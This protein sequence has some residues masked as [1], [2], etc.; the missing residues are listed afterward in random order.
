MD[1]YTLTMKAI[2]WIFI[3]FST[4]IF[5][6]TSDNTRNGT[7]LGFFH[8]KQLPQDY[9]LWTEAQ[10]RYLLDSSGMQQT[11]YRIGAL[12]KIND[13]H[14]VGLIY[15][16]VQTGIMKEHRP[17]LQHVQQYGE[18]SGMKLSGRTRLEFRMLEDSPDDAMRFR[19]QLRMQRKLTQNLDLVVWDE[20]FINLTKDDWT[21]NRTVERNRFFIGT[22]I[23]FWDMNAEIGYMNQFVPRVKDI[24]EH[25]L[26]LYLFY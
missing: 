15:G 10:F 3:L 21:G 24:T 25:I 17:T 19:Y 26:T 6:A 12:K 18:L 4:T 23:P 2:F 20:P 11:L 8:K 5:A 1:R 9:A 7:W 22:K 14:E 16:F 13:S